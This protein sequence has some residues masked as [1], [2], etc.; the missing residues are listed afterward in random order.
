MCNDNITDYL[1]RKEW[2]NPVSRYT[3]GVRDRV[4][5]YHLVKL[6]LCK[7]KI[8]VK[9]LVLKLFNRINM[10]LNHIITDQPWVNI[11]F[12]LLWGRE[13]LSYKGCGD[14][15]EC[16]NFYCHEKQRYA[17]FPQQEWKIDKCVKPIFRKFASCKQLFWA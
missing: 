16:R 3:H 7:L 1:Q 4:P 14:S 17:Y 6:N 8:C 15:S 9:K 12:E 2:R 13:S 10:V 5:T 11:V